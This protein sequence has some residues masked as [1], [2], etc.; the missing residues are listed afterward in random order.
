MY[1]NTTSRPPHPP[2]TPPPKPTDQ[3]L[4]VLVPLVA[5]QL[6]ALQ[7]IN[8]PT[9]QL[10]LVLV[11]LVAEQLEALRLDLEGDAAPKGGLGWLRLLRDDQAPL[12]YNN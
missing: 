11:P 6:K 9:D 10:L 7:S 5:E 4:L 1:K 12:F 2:P 8:Q 3:L